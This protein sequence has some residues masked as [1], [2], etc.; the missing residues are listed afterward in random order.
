VVDVALASSVTITV[1]TED[2]ENWGQLVLK[3][4][5]KQ[6]VKLINPQCQT[7]LIRFEP[8][9]Q[10]ARTATMA[11][12]WRSRAQRDHMAIVSL[13]RFLATKLAQADSLVFFHFDADV[14]WARRDQC[15]TREQFAVLIKPQIRLLL[16]GRGRSLD[17]VALCMQRL[18]EIV[19][20][21]SIEA[22][23]Y[24]NNDAL[25]RACRTHCGP[26]HPQHAAL[27]ETWATDPGCLD[28]IAMVKRQACVSNKKNLQLVESGFPWDRLMQVR[29][30]FFA[31]VAQAQSR[32]PVV[33]AIRLVS[34]PPPN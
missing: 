6:I 25:L 3:R 20:H 4:F 23:T 24:Q 34:D 2:S 1:L 26:Q 12:K 16:Q 9:P 5:A 28:E 21:Y 22:W 15:L 10:A 11:N 31:V 14:T 18:I 19:P 13:R 29:K 30:S 33:E 7:Q 32:N 8:T 17:D 27:Y